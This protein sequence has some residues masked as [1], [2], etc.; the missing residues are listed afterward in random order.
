VNKIPAYDNVQSLL[1][2]KGGAQLLH[3]ACMA[4]NVTPYRK[5][6]MN[7]INDI[8]QLS[9]MQIYLHGLIPDRLL[10]NAWKKENPWCLLNQDLKKRHPKCQH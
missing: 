5:K 4:G 10:Q 8:A 7:G 2:S 1:L 9:E 6:N 3:M